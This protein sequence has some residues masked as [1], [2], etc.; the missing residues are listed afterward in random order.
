VRAIARRYDH[1]QAVRLL[2]LLLAVAVMVSIVHYSDNYA[3]YAD[4]PQSRTVPNPSAGLIVAAWFAFT[5][6]GLAGYLAFR[7]AP[8]NLALMLLA[9]YSGSGLIGIGHYLV[10]GATSM[11]W[12]R[13]LHVGCDIACG[14]AIFSF[15][16]WVARARSSAGPPH[17]RRYR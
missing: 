8:S 6:A 10:P 15:A 2:T 7:R 3:N 11:P 17:P 14:I 9:A 16:V 13:Q 12:W 4:Y 1:P 5:A